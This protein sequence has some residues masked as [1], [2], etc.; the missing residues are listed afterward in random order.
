MYDENHSRACTTP[1]ASTNGF[2]LVVER[3]TRMPAVQR[4]DDAADT[5][6]TNHSHGLP[7]FDAAQHVIYGLSIMIWR[8][9]RIHYRFTQCQLFDDDARNAPATSV[10]SCSPARASDPARKRMPHTH[11]MTPFA[12]F[13][14]PSMRSMHVGNHPI[15]APLAP[16]P[17]ASAIGDTPSHILSYMTLVRRGGLGLVLLAAN[18]AA[19]G[20][21]GPD[22]MENQHRAWSKSIAVRS[23]TC[24]RTSTPACLGACVW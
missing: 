1:L 23:G 10:C 5:R 15:L 4:V 6:S 9:C 2:E 19:L 20:S 18:L 7:K 12:S 14:T 21:R 17:S 22:A 16:P 11:S 24:W 13:T 8:I 3:A